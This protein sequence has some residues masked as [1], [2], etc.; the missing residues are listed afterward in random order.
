MSLLYTIPFTLL[1][2]AIGL[3]AA[4]STA[5]L[6]TLT[7]AAALA[8]REAG[9]AARR[10]RD[11]GWEAARLRLGV[12]IPAHN[13][14]MVI[15]AALASLAK[16]DYPRECFEVIVIADNC[17]DRTP[18]L[19]R[20]KGATVLERSNPHEA[21]KGYALD[22][23]FTRILA[24]DQ[25]AD[26]FIILDADTWAAPDFL[27]RMAERLVAGR[28]GR[29]CCALQ[30][31]YGVLNA[32]EGWRAALM[33]AAFELCNH[34]KLLGAD[35]IGCW[36]GLKGNGM[37][38]SREVLECARWSG[39]SITEDVD[40]GLDLLSHYRIRVGYVPE[41]R[42]LAQMPTTGAQA[43][44]QRERWE[45]GRYGLVAVRVPRLL[46]EA[47]AWRDLRLLDAVFGLLVPP[48]AELAFLIGLWGALIAA[49][50]HAHL[51][52]GIAAWEAAVVLC[53]FGLFLYVVGGLR[54]AGAPAAAYSAL[55][56]APLYA[57]WKFALYG[58][59]FLARHTHRAGGR[60]WVR[61]ERAPIDLL[62]GA[63]GADVAWKPGTRR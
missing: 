6:L 44:S 30:G 33:S 14:E 41:A 43:G 10:S 36:V 51:L 40:Y 5:Y 48:L 49:G 56:R 55:A 37:A 47:I 58:G 46:R 16:Q 15:E 63:P 53:G 62:P 32:D 54:V 45:R 60:Q 22:W 29:G 12:V 57:A 31:R 35:R 42:V 20:E 3:L 9:R 24:A 25:P 1:V 23:A 28:D 8:R 17:T 39:R 52:P 50:G 11:G 7:V 34:V 26:A 2:G 27:R 59:R 61:T 21:G 18:E 4:G 38:F 13:E 19:A